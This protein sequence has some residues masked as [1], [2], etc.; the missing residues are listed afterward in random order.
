MNRR[1]SGCERL[2]CLPRSARRWKPMSPTPVFLFSLPRSGSTLVQRMLATSSQVA[3]ATEPWVLLPHLYAFRLDGAY[4]EYGHRTAARALADF[5]AAMPDGRRAYL[6]EVRRSVL[7][8]YARAAGEAIYFLDK[9]PRYHLVVDEIVELFP[10]APCIF[11]WRH[12]LAVAAS[13][14]ESF[15][16]GRW[17]LFRYDVDLYGGLERLVAARRRSRSCHAVRYEDVVTDPARAIAR[18]FAFLDLP[19][20]GDTLGRFARVRMN[21]RMG[22]RI[23]SGNYSAVTTEPL[24]KWQ[25]TMSNPLRKRWC[26]EYVEWIGS[27]RLEVMGYDREAILDE[28]DALPTSGRTVGSDIARRAHGRLY[29]RRVAHVTA[30]RSRPSP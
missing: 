17:N 22:D 14:I 3:T 21:G 6:D 15:G 20:P 2:M 25:V 4:A 23:G 7:A 8:L 26:R 9:T 5:C 28:V 18:M 10:E 30:R 27:E 11:L 13:M 16:S 1:R 24:A 19:V 29:R 12:P